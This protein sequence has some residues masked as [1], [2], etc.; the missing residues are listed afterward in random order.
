M[1]FLIVFLLVAL[2]FRQSIAKEQNEFKCS[3]VEIIFFSIDPGLKNQ[4]R[5]IIELC[6]DTV[7]DNQQIRSFSGY[8][9][10]KR[11]PAYKAF[12]NARFFY[13]EKDSCYLSVDAFIFGNANFISYYVN[14]KWYHKKIPPQLSDYLNKFNMSIN[15]QKYK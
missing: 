7:T 8:K 11:Y 3:M 13:Y 6:K 14:N 12:P 4:D 9:K 2:F 1:R 10:W 5:G 15:C